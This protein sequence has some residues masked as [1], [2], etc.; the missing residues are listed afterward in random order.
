M[1]TSKITIKGTEYTLAF[2]VRA[3]SALEQRFGGLAKM[4]DAINGDNAIT[5]I[6]Y[7]LGVLLDCGRRHEIA[8]GAEVS[9]SVPT[10]DDILDTMT[11]EELTESVQTIMRA[12]GG[13]SEQT[14]K[15]DPPKGAKSKNAKATGRR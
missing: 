13:G 8:S 9:G 14:V 7:V 1:K 6:A 12:I 3:A 5:S 15:A 4:G 2:T 11:V 10:E